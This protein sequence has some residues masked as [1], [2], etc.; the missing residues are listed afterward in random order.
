MRWLPMIFGGT[1]KTTQS[2]SRTR[3]FGKAFLMHSKQSRERVPLVRQGRFGLVRPAE[4][5]RFEC[6]SKN[7]HDKITRK[8]NNVFLAGRRYFPLLRVSF[9]LKCPSN[10]GNTIVI[11]GKRVL[12]SESKACGYFFVYSGSTFELLSSQKTT[13]ITP[14]SE[15]Q[16]RQSETQNASRPA[17]VTVHRKPGG[18]RF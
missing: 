2:M 7:I 10:Y 18:K 8:V 6:Q 15:L 14:S 12:S 1:S 16:C 4:S 11:E 3:I 9:P 13:C 5:P 17:P